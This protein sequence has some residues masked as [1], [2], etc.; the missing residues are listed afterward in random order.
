[1]PSNNQ[2]ESQT[3]DVATETKIN[4]RRKWKLICISSRRKLA[5]YFGE[6][7]FKIIIDAEAQ[8]T[9]K[10]K[11]NLEKKEFEPS[12]VGVNEDE[13]LRVDDCVTTIEA[14]NFL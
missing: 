7:G 11:A 4:G 13:F 2:W 1:M 5:G 6:K 10:D 9:V 12:D 3:T 14:T 8:T